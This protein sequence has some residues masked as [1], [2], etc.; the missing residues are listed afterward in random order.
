MIKIPKLPPSDE[1]E[2]KEKAFFVSVHDQVEKL[3]KTWIY[4]LLGVI[5]L[6]WPVEFGLK[7]VFTKILISSIPTP[8][9]VQQNLTPQDLQILKVKM[10]PVTAGVI[11]AVAQVLNPNPQIS[12]LQLDYSFVFKDSSGIIIKRALA[13]S[14]FYPTESKFLALPA[15]NIDIIPA[16]ID[17]TFDKIKWSGREPKTK[18]NLQVFQQKTGET[19][20]GKFYLEALVKNLEGFVIKRVE[21]SEL[22]FDKRNRDVV[23]INSTILT[24]LKPQESRYFRSEWPISKKSLF[25]YGFGSIQIIPSV[26]L[27]SS[28]FDLNSE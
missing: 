12:V 3:S 18:V 6:S 27:F 20:E 10:I 2:Y 24:D 1:L 28:G 22:V 8:I 4:V 16:S 17:L 7:K 13:Q 25:P 15:V 5:V 21:V 9:A 19:P 23:A 26:N 11:S 14:Y